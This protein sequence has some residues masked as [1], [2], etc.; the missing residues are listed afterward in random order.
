MYSDGK[1][2]FTSRTLAELLPERRRVSHKGNYGRVLLLAGS[3]GMAGAAAI[4]AM[5]ALRTGAGLVTVACPE[6]VL[7][8][9]QMLCPCA[10]CLP[11][12][13]DADEAWQLLEGAV[14]RCDAFGAGCGLG[15]TEWS[16][17]LLRRLR[18][19]LLLIAR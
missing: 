16:A 5:A 11:L 8:V 18:R 2:G 10:T 1:G 13:E 19:R 12:P 9:V 17:E 3:R 4:A 6:A 7:N 14:E 15:Q